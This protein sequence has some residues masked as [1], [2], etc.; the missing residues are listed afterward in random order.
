MSSLLWTQTRS[1]DLVIEDAL[2]VQGMTKSNKLKA[3]DYAP[4]CMITGNLKGHMAR[5]AT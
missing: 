4:S 2:R 5:C 3:E 1:N